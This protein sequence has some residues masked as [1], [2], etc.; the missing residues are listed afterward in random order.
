[1]LKDLEADMIG[2]ED[3]M[4]GRKSFAKAIEQASQYED[5]SVADPTAEKVA[6]NDD[7]QPRLNGRRPQNEQE[8]RAEA[9]A[10]FAAAAAVIREKYDVAVIWKAPR[11][12]RTRTTD[13]YKFWKKPIM[14]FLDD[15]TM[16]DMG[17]TAL[18]RLFAPAELN[19]SV[20]KDTFRAPLSEPAR[21][22]LRR[23]MT[24][25]GLSLKLPTNFS[26]RDVQK[27]MKQHRD[28]SAGVEAYKVNVEIVGEEIYCNGK[29]FK[30]Q[31]TGSGKR[32]IRAGDG[33]LP[34][35]SLTAFLSSQT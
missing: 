22:E 9:V 5:F 33:W 24:L 6:E 11:V 20:T 16:L 17:P 7:Q 10:A 35:A 12:G 28:R 29:G 3:R 25:R 19:F 1:L 31:R 32:R 23:L 27:A 13:E 34:I 2:R 21:R 30:M 14:A 26:V 15:P 4:N 8:A 18:A